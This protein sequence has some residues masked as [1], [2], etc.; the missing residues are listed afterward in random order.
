VTDLFFQNGKIVYTI[1]PEDGGFDTEIRVSQ[2]V[3]EPGDLF[4]V[5]FRVSL[6]KI[7]GK[8]LYRFPNHLKVSDDRI[9]SSSIRDKFIK[10]DPGSVLLDVADSLKNIIKILEH[11]SMHRRPRQEYTP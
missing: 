11:R 4:P 8:I 7:T 1:V 5:G 2:D 10:R 6:L 3:T 9:L